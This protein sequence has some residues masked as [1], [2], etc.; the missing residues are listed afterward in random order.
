LS[1]ADK[2][3]KGGLSWRKQYSIQEFGVRRKTIF[4]CCFELGRTLLIR[5]QQNK[6]VLTVRI[7]AFR[8]KERKKEIVTTD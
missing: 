2:G 7:Y 3:C 4:L 6:K 1:D 8:K 5:N